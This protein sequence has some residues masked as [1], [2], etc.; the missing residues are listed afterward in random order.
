MQRAQSQN[1]CVLHQTDSNENVLDHFLLDTF[2]NKHVLN[3]TICLNNW[4]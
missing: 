2:Y 4:L 1:E 3:G